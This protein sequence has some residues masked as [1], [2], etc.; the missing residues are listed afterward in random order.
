VTR[1]ALIAIAVAAPFIIAA[2]VASGY[3]SAKGARRLWRSVVI[4]G[5]GAVLVGLVLRTGGLP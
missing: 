2:L 4:L 5:V 1:H 3:D